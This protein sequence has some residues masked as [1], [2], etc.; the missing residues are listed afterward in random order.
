M[1]PVTNDEGRGAAP[2]LRPP[3][4]LF[5]GEGPDFAKGE[6]WVDYFAQVCRLEADERV[7]DVGCG[8]GRV[9]IPLSRYLT[10]GS[11]E[12]FDTGAREVEWC[13]SHITPTATNFRFVHANV[14]NK[15]YNPAGTIQPDDFRFPYPDR[16]FD[17]VLL[18]S[19]FTHMLPRDVE[20]YFSEIGRVLKP[21][22]RWLATYFL[23]NEESVALIEEGRSFY[24]FKHDL[25]EYRAVNPAQ[26][27]DAVA[28]PEQY[29][30]TLYE[31]FGYH[32]TIDY[33]QWSG[34]DPSPTNRDGQDIVLGRPEQTA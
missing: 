1:N 13:Q 8:S 27:E 21:D 31:R 2:D 17:F 30:R 26:H 6:Q 28:Y 23:L 25:G 14:F 18:T 5:C 9:A 10:R 24:D 29:V 34:R 4:E 16:E 15:T 20:H 19:V 33:G 12:G 11:Y 7:L 3:K 32:C 22:G